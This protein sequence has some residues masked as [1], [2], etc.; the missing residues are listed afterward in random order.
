MLYLFV[1][2]GE[3]FYPIFFRITIKVY[4]P[5]HMYAVRTYLYY[6]TNLRK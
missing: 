6:M 4:Q 1:K 2:F 3:L 5:S